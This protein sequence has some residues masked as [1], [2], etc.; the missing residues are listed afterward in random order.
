MAMNRRILLAFVA[1]MLFTLPV[2]AQQGLP[3]VDFATVYPH[4]VW[5]S[6]EGRDAEYPAG[7]RYK[8]LSVKRGE[9]VEFVLIRDV[10]NGTKTIA[11][12]AKGAISKFEGAASGMLSRLGTKFDVS[13]ERFDFREI[14]SVEEFKKLAAKIGWDVD[15]M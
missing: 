15:P 3:A 2:A 12:H 6:T 1:T 11:M 9:Q 5:V 10:A 14:T 4:L 8:L 13:F 7:F